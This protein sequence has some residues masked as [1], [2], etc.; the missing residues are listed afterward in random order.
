MSL[1]SPHPPKPVL[2]ARRSCAAIYLSRLAMVRILQHV[3]F[4]SSAICWS[5]CLLTVAGSASAV[6]PGH[7][8]RAAPETRDRPCQVQLTAVRQEPTLTGSRARPAE[9]VL[10]TGASPRARYFLYQCTAHQPPPR[11]AQ[12]IAVAK[13]SV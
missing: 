6:K 2:F 9:V 8:A 13:N 5:C 12:V 7:A 3:L 4:R 10:S 1:P 11:T